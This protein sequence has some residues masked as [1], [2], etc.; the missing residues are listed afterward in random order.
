MEN[1]ILRTTYEIIKVLEYK[2]SKTFK[3]KG[4]KFER[5]FSLWGDLFHFLGY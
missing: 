2:E 5:R 4:E 3:L 1:D